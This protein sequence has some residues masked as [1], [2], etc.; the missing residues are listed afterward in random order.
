MKKK[1]ILLITIILISGLVVRI[2]AGLKTPILDYHSSQQ[3]STMSV[4]KTF[5]IDGI[6][7]LY[8]RHNDSYNFQKNLENPQQFYFYEFPLYTA[9]IA[10]IY[11]II[12]FIPIETIARSL[13]A[14]SSLLTIFFIYFLTLKL[15]GRT[16]AIL[17]SLL[18]TFFPFFVF[19]SRVTLS[20]MF[21]TSAYMAAIFFIYL[22]KNNDKRVQFLWYI[23]SLFFFA[24]AVLIRPAFLLFFPSIILFFYQKHGWEIYK[25]FPLYIFLSTTV[26]LLLFWLKH[27]YQYPEGITFSYFLTDNIKN[28]SLLETITPSHLFF[29]DVIQEHVFTYILGGLLIIYIFIFISFNKSSRFLDLALVSTLFYLLIFQEKHSQYEFYQIIILPFLAMAVGIGIQKAHVIFKK[30]NKTFILI[31]TILVVSYSFY[32]SYRQSTYYFRV[33]DDQQQIAKV[34][35]TLTTQEDYIITDTDGNTTL[36]YISER[37]GATVIFDTPYI[38]RKKGYSYVFTDKKDTREKFKEEYNLKPIFE[39]SSFSLFKI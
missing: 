20:D 14:V 3:S 6:N 30:E 2:F 26:L 22:Y 5:S 23:M 29:E 9:S 32:I 15:Y 16:Q 12:P 18:F 4:A 17:S 34:I 33:N 7:L 25:K 38:L 28:F 10:L 13:T 1:D 11:S 19:Y 36:L 31:L 35:K 27:V 21:A 39:N 24:I 8:P 37:K